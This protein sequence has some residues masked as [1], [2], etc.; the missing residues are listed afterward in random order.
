MRAIWTGAI[1]FGLVNIP[2]KLHSAVQDS[3]LDLDMLDSKD[4]S[5]IKFKRVN[6]HTGKE[7]AYDDIVRGYMY[8]EH[9]VVLDDADFKAADVKKTN[10]I[11]IMH[12]VD[13]A[14]IDSIYYEQPYY[15][16]PDKSGV[17][18]YAILRDALE[19]SGKVGVTSFVLRN[20]EALAILKPYG[21]V[22]VLN[23]IRFEEEIREPG[24]LNLP[25]PEKARSKELEMANKLIEQ[26]TEE[27]DISTYKDTYTANLLKRIQLKAKSKGKKLPEPKLK[28]VH[29]KGKDDLMEMLKASLS[30]GSKA[31]ASKKSASKSKTKT[32]AAAAPVKRR[33]TA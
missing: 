29:T 24:D 1:S 14:E 2:V 16:A 9:Y 25:S 26:L 11:E 10:T 22:I 8:K 28:V 12:F 33:K 31:S 7:V 27:F 19:K 17:K 21:K 3:S 20:R 4:H 5:N 18:A 30:G 6:E 23:K 32:K 15:L 13:A